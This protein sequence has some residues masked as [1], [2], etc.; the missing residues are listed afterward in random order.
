MMI[1]RLAFL[2]QVATTVS[3]FQALPQSPATSRSVSTRLH[4]TPA[5]AIATLSTSQENIIRK[6]QS[7]I[8]D[9][10]HKPDFTWNGSEVVVDSCPVTLDARDAA[11][12]SNVAWLSSLC[13]HSKMSSLQV[14]N[15]PLNDVPHL[16][17]RCVIVGGD[18]MRLTIDFRP[19]AYGAYEMRRP[20]GSYPGP[21]ELGRKS[22]EYSGARMDYDKKF[23]T[24]EVKEFL[25]SLPLEGAVPCDV[26]PTE[27][28]L[29]TRGPLY[30]SLD[31]P[32]TE[33]NVDVVVAAR[34]K[35]AYY[36]LDWTQ[37]TE[38]EH[39]PGAPINS[40]YVYDTKYK[41][42]AFG[43]LMSEYT[44]LFGADSGKELAIGD[45]G[46]LDEAYVGGGS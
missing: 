35:A 9:L 46:P 33:G 23:G 34:E 21:D 40:Q 15:G 10:E 42:N 24:E 11:G 32:L 8:S 39:R 31:M 22:F 27:L 28:D 36:W 29:L 43:A 38:H 20:D 14:F 30:T 2:L 45:S 19:R 5:E 4:V 7:T 1:A 3:G 17:S 13:V 26:A 16:V 6:I 18:K 12:P 37:E 41:Q 44:A 25:S